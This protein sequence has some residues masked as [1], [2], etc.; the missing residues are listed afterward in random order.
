MDI[1]RKITLQIERKGDFIVCRTPMEKNLTLGTCSAAQ[2]I[3]MY[4]GIKKEGKITYIPRNVIQ[5]RITEIQARIERDSEKLKI[6]QE[7]YEI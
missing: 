4:K 7:I 2:N 5:A 1:T 6:M 3:H